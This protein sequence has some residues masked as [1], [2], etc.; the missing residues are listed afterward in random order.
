[1][2]APKASDQK[3]VANSMNNIPSLKASNSMQFNN[4]EKNTH[5]TR[6]ISPFLQRNTDNSNP[7]N[8]FVVAPYFKDDTDLRKVI[9]KI[10]RQENLEFGLNYLTDHLE[11]HPGTNLF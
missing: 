1:M 11:K 2:K 5:G 6:H 9:E 4:N 3:T 7:A 8:S 10:K